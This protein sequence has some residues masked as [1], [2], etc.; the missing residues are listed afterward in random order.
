MK[1]GRKKFRPF[2]ISAAGNSGLRDVSENTIT[3]WH[4]LK[5]LVPRPEG[6]THLPRP[7]NLILRG[8]QLR[9]RERPAAVQLLRANSHLGAKTKLSAVGETSRSIPVHGSGVHAAQ[10]LAGIGLS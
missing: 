1:S 4:F 9:Q 5:Q 7:N 3:I 8:G 10:E 2:R 6:S